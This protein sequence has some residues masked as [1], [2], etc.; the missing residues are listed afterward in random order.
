[1][2]S[3]LAILLRGAKIVSKRG[4]TADVFRRQKMLIYR[5]R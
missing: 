2:V 5:G 1:V 3:R 4:V